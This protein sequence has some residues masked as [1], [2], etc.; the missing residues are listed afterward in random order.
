[1][2]VYICAS[3]SGFTPLSYYSPLLLDAST[4][5]TFARYYHGSVSPEL[6]RLA[7]QTSQ[8][9]DI[10]FLCEDDDT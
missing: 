7:D 5:Q 2:Q 1:M 9:Y 8:R 3:C 6:D 10:F 4:S